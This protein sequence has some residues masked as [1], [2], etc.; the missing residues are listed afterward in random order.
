VY[1]PNP[2]ELTLQVALEVTAP[3]LT[4]QLIRHV[5]LA[6]NFQK[7]QN[8]IGFTDIVAPPP[9][10]ATVG[11]AVGLFAMMQVSSLAG[12]HYYQTVL[13]L[14]MFARQAVSHC[15]DLTEI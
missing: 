2:S 7:S 1:V 8:A 11:V 13:L 4:Q 5:L 10:G 6:N 3:L 9:L 15:P 12:A 14:G